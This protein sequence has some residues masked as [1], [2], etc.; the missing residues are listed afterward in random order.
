M[1]G[2]LIFSRSNVLISLTYNSKFLFQKLSNILL[3]QIIIYNLIIQQRKCLNNLAGLVS[4]FVFTISQLIQKLRVLFVFKD[5]F[6]GLVKKISLVCGGFCLNF[7][8]KLLFYQQFVLFY[9]DILEMCSV[10]PSSKH[11]C[12]R[13]TFRKF[14]MYKSKE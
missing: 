4:Y 13:K 14:Y 1:C 7:K 9:S 8:K 11:Y 2:C 10:T 5:I 12:C 3:G 6:A